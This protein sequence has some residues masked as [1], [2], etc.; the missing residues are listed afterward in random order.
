MPE[1]ARDR[2]HSFLEKSAHFQSLISYGE[3]WHNNHH[4]YLH[5]AAHGL[6]W[7]EFDTTYLTIR[8]L[9]R[10]RLATNIRLPRGG[11]AKLPTLTLPPLLA[12]QPQASVAS[13]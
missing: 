11:P 6:R 2:V 13:A 5:S 12:Q 7:W 4:A 10:M 8:V 9:A 3:G 1:L